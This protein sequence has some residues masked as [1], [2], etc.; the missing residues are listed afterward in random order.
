MGIRE[1]R[2]IVDTLLW[3]VI[4]FL[5]AL[6]L[7]VRIPPYFGVIVFVSFFTIG[8]SLVRKALLLWKERN[9]EKDKDET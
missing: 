6:F 8:V 4:M 7:S 5:C 1:W 2:Q 3:A 9:R